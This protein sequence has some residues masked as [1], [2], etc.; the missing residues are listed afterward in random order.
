MTGPI[1]VSA[2][3]WYETMT[4]GEAVTLVHEPWIKPF[5]C[6][7]RCNMWQIAKPQRFQWWRSEARTRHKGPIGPRPSDGVLHQ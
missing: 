4:M 7:N 2:A 1:A 3:E 6:C 5:F